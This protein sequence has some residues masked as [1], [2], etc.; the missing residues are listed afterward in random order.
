MLLPRQCISMPFSVL[1]GSWRQMTTTTTTN[2]PCPRDIIKIT[3]VGGQMQLLWWGGWTPWPPFVLRKVTAASLSQTPL[4]LSLSLL[5][6]NIVHGRRIFI[7][8]HTYT[9][10]REYYFLFSPVVPVDDREKVEGRTP[11]NLEPQNVDDCTRVLVFDSLQENIRRPI[12]KYTHKT[13][14]GTTLQSPIYS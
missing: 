11:N 1:F 10:I 12:F 7:Y 5:T 2:N 6:M 4:S 13:D 9:Y 3:W 8:V 14:Y